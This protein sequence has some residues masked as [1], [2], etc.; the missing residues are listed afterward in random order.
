MDEYTDAQQP[1]CVVGWQYTPVIILENVFSLFSR[2]SDLYSCSIVCRHWLHVFRSGRQW[3]HLRIGKR[4]FVRRKFRVPVRRWAEVEG[5]PS[6]VSDED[7]EPEYEI[8]HQR[9][10]FYLGKFGGHCQQLCMLPI[11]SYFNLYELLRVSERA[12]V[13]FC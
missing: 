4:S 13:E 12:P 6:T 8:D 9:L 3:R 10:Q 5:V 11:T 1:D 7:L 2:L